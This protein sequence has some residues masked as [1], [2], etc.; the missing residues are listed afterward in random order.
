[1][2]SAKEYEMLHLMKCNVADLAGYR[3][4]STVG[5]KHKNKYLLT[6]FNVD[7]MFIK[8]FAKFVKN[9]KDEKKVLM[10]GIQDMFHYIINV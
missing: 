4:Y 7:E 5:Y 10:K 3:E 6:N 1:M 2:K 9:V 8:L